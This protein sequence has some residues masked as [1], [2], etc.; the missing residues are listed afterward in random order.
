MSEPYEEI[1]EGETI[2]RFPPPPRHEQILQRLRETLADH[3]RK[4]TVSRLLTPRSIVQFSAGTFLRP[5][6]TVVATPTGKPWLVVE[7]IH[8]EDHRMDTVLKKDIYETCRIPRLWIVDA[9]YDNAEVYHTGTYGL[10]L[11]SMLA[12]R[13]SLT[14]PL[15]PQMALTMSSLF[16]PGAS[17]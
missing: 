6:L 17:S 4:T 9:R 1:V 12:G 8:A 11:K 7:I 14:D 15:L 16:A 2:L 13:E 3:I 5:D 10:A